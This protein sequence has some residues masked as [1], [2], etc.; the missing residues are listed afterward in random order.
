[1]QCLP[2]DDVCVI[3][4]KLVAAWASREFAGHDDSSHGIA[5]NKYANEARLLFAFINI[6]VTNH[7]EQNNRK[8]LG[9][10]QPPS[11][12]RSCI[13]TS[14]SRWDECLNLLLDILEILSA[15]AAFSQSNEKKFHCWISLTT[16]RNFLHSVLNRVSFKD[17]LKSSRN[18][19]HVKQW[20]HFVWKRLWSN[21]NRH[22]RSC[23]VLLSTSPRLG[24]REFCY[25]FLFHNP[26]I[27]IL[28]RQAILSRSSSPR[29]TLCS[30]QPR[31]HVTNWFK[32]PF[33]L[34]RM[35]V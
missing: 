13:K 23:P 16:F 32:I 9:D 17:A 2:H 33:I 18:G 15:F 3:V 35:V 1:M 12:F 11:A 14:T 7:Q 24:W 27:R 29:W 21:T 25:F 31:L 30:T 28:L 22:T 19:K 34:S 5:P 26:T 4:V 20:V 10:F 8:S 6:E